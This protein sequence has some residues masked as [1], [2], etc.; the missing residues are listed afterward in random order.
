MSACLANMG[1]L[2]VVSALYFFCSSQANAENVH[3]TT[4]FVL[5]IDPSMFNWTL[6]GNGDHFSYRPSLL[7]APDLPPW[8][9]Y[10]YSNRH[11]SGFLYGVPPRDQTDVELEIVGLNRETYETRRHV[12]H[13]N[14]IEKT[15]PARF[16]V[17]LKVDNLN[18][19]DLFDA[20]R[21]AR[22]LDVFRKRLWRESEPDLHLTFLASAVYLG[23]RRP[24]RPTEEEGV[25][26]RVGS[27]NGFSVALLELQEEVRPLWRVGPS[28]PR[29]F[30]RTTVDRLFREEGFALDWC[31][32]RLL[33]E[34]WDRV[35]DPTSQPSPSSS[36]RPAASVGAANS[37]GQ[38]WNGVGGVDDVHKT[39]IDQDEDIWM[40]VPS[41]QGVPQR[42]YARE[43]IFSILVPTLALLVLVVILSLLLCFHHEGMDDVS[44]EY[45]ESVFDIFEDYLRSKRIDETPAVQMVQYEAVHRATRTLRSLSSNRASPSPSL[46]SSMTLPLSSSPR[47]TMDRG[48]LHPNPPP[49]SSSTTGRT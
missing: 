25:V 5:P 49:Y 42:S 7:N 44:S 39:R 16:E 29:D 35:D 40:V 20:A 2:W 37:K 15:N 30:K 36:R 19:E 26:L 47:Q 18:V 22:L 23:A 41:K 13:V 45:F 21:L 6:N 28:C 3:M 48:L 27:A 33:E 32:F 1:L 34:D 24:L 38:P 8:I 17:A 31:A 4:V 11:R 14:V 12:V 10:V 46:A 43:F 9:H